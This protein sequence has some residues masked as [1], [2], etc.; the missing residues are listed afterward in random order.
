M[1]DTLIVV[2]VELL[3]CNQAGRNKPGVLSQSVQEFS[4]SSLLKSQ[5][6]ISV[7]KLCVLQDFGMLATF[8]RRS[9][10]TVKR[11]VEQFK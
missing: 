7:H 1:N 5:L 2:L 3:S 4:I 9:F 11:N 8:S 10:S 6:L